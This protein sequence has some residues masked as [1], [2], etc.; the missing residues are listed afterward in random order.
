MT[1]FTAITHIKSSDNDII[2]F[3]TFILQNKCVLFKDMLKDVQE[4]NDMQ[5]NITQSTQTIKRFLDY[6]GIGRISLP[7][8]YSH[9]DVLEYILDIFTLADMW[10]LKIVQSPLTSIYHSIGKIRSLNRKFAKVYTHDIM[11]GMLFMSVYHRL[12]GKK[13][14]EHKDFDIIWGDIAYDNYIDNVEWIDAVKIFNVPISEILNNKKL[15]NIIEKIHV[16][17]CYE[18]KQHKVQTIM[19]LNTTMFDQDST[20]LIIPK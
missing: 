17:D 20:Y 5:I 12:M 18:L 9:N 15:L 10:N 16:K 1:D 4:N 6:I 7:G 14:H 19:D 13:R 3:P 11:E 2:G 8:K